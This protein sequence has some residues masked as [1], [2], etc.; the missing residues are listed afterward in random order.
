MLLVLS[1]CCSSFHANANPRASPLVAAGKLGSNSRLFVP[2]VL[3]MLVRTFQLQATDVSLDY[4]MYLISCNIGG[5]DDDICQKRRIERLEH[6]KVDSLLYIR[7]LI[8]LTYIL[9]YILLTVRL[10][11]NSNI[12]VLLCD[13]VLECMHTQ[14]FYFRDRLIK[15]FV[16]QK[17]YKSVELQSFRFCVRNAPYQIF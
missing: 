6:H 4:S 16:G 14:L 11:W 17:L 7:I 15:I 8:F 5:L 12:Y 2:V 3:T 10:S 9:E 1:I 13:D